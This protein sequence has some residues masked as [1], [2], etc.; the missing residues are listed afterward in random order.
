MY[1]HYLHTLPLSRSLSLSLSLS[2][3]AKAGSMEQTIWGTAKE[4]MS[5]PGGLYRGFGLKLLRSVPASMIGFVVYEHVA[6]QLSQ[7]MT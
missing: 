6:Q 3:R 1:T 7:S 2:T 5:E 4:L